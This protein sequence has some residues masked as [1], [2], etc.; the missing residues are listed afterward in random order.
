MAK[1]WQHPFNTWVGRRLP[2]HQQ[3]FF[4]GLSVDVFTADMEVLSLI[5]SD[6]PG[7]LAVDM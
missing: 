4:P 3:F 1:T 5:K 6:G 2:G 7:V